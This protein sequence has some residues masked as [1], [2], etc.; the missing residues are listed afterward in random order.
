MVKMLL[1]SLISKIVN[2]YTVKDYS[3]DEQDTGTKWIDGKTVYKRTVTK[4]QTNSDAVAISMADW[5]ADKI[6]DAEV[7]A[8]GGNYQ[9]FTTYY[10]SSTDRLRL[11]RNGN[12]LTLDSGSSYPPKPTTWY[13]TLYYTKN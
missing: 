9:F 6:I 10:L 1:K 8:V 2:A 3:L 7:L 12:T 4:T 13:L 11:Y 5:S